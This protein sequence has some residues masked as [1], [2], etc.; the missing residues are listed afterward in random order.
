MQSKNLNARI[1]S[2]VTNCYV[3]SLKIESKSPNLNDVYLNTL[4]TL[5]VQLSI[6]ELFDVIQLLIAWKFSPERLCITLM[7][8]LGDLLFCHVV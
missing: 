7:Q 1:G 8:A 2:D 4:E 5:F 3:W 6:Q